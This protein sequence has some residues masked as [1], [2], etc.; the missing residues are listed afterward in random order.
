MPSCFATEAEAIEIHIR[1]MDMSLDDGENGLVVRATISRLDV[2]I[3]PQPPEHFR[4]GLPE[5][6]G[7]CH[8]ENLHY[9]QAV[10]HPRALA[11]FSANEKRKVL[12]NEADER[13]EQD[14]GDAGRNTRLENA[15]TDEPSL[16]EI[17]DET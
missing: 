2:R 8:P 5:I 10:E 9:A 14:C 15:C 11:C 3:A 1:S 7:Q 13:N 12:T 6:N 16:T 17:P 4:L